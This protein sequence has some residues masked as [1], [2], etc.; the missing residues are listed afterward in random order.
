MVLYSVHLN[1][2]I[3]CDKRQEKYTPLPGHGVLQLQAVERHP[4]TLASA[5]QIAP[6][7][8]T[9]DHNLVAVRQALTEGLFDVF[10]RVQAGG[11]MTRKRP[12]LVLSLVAAN[13]M[14]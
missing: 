2:G 5:C 1:H 8:I 12:L 11:I 14:V 7:C 3:A 13:N 10:L 9:I 4:R 6:R